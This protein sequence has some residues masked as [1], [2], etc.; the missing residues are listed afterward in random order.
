MNLQN[1]AQAN[2]FR[3][4]ALRIVCESA[5]VLWFCTNRIFGQKYKA[6]EKM[7]LRR[8]F[9]S[10]AAGVEVQR[11]TRRMAPNRM[12]SP[13]LA[14]PESGFGTGIGGASEIR[15]DRTVPLSKSSA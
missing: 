8:T 14:A 3:T 9:S 6:L 15:T 1:S 12:L 2:A 11:S 5:D 13:Q 4:L 10:V 7:G